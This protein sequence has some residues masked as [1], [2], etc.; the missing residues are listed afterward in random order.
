MLMMP[1]TATLVAVYRNNTNHYLDATRLARRHGCPREIA[2]VNDD[3]TTL[4]AIGRHMIAQA[5]YNSNCR[6]GRLDNYRHRRHENR[7]PDKCAP[8]RRASSSGV[9]WCCS[10]CSS[11]A[12]HKTSSQMQHTGVEG[13]SG[14]ECTA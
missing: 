9:G 6:R 5:Q 4:N 7:N 1:L 11:S 13:K 2:T 14:C 3:N 10:L 8:L 12:T